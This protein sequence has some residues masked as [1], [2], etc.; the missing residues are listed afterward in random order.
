[1]KK[2][3]ETLVKS[4]V[5]DNRDYIEENFLDIEE[6]LT[7]WMGEDNWEYDFFDFDEVETK[8]EEQLEE[9]VREFAKRYR[10]VMTCEIQDNLEDILE[11]DEDCNYLDEPGIIEDLIARDSYDIYASD[12]GAD[13]HYHSIFSKLIA[14][15]GNIRQF[16]KYYG[17][18]IYD[19]REAKQYECYK[20]R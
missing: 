13:I 14:A 6:Y 17:F 11:E 3:I 5:N 9:E 2:E 15:G 18:G 10:G 19:N 7:S 4:W 1:M 16:A 8:T 20:I 12:H